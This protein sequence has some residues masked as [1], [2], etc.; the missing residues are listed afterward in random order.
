MREDVG[1]K[2]KAYFIGDLVD[3]RRKHRRHQ[4]ALLFGQPRAIVEEQVAPHDGQP[5][6]PRAAHGFDRIVEGCLGSNGP[7]DRQHPVIMDE[8]R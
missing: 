1:G 5:V 2:A 3:E 7:F 8:L 6:A 4:R